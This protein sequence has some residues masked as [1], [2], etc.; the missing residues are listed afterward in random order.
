MDFTIPACSLTTG[1]VQDL[2]KICTTDMAPSMNGIN[3]GTFYAMANVLVCDF[4]FM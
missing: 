1:S 2:Y 4:I 3:G